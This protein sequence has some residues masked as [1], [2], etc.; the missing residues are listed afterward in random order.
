MTTITV[1]VQN[2]EDAELL[3][4]FIQKTDFK[5]EVEM[6][7]EADEYTVE[8]VAEWNER[9]EAYEKDP[10]RGKTIEEAR[11]ILKK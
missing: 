4:N 11:Q 1:N 9:L 5:E 6:F 7:E 3:K 10:T 2:Q 8:D